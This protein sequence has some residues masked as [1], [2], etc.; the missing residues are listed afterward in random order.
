[1]AFKVIKYFTDLQDNNHAYEVDSTYPREGLN[2]LPS[3]IR[4]LAGS[5]NRRG[6]PLIVEVEEP[7]NKKT[8]EK[9]SDE[10]ESV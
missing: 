1:M 7:K 4:E 6:E 8:T 10:T 3:R 9:V 5:N 2:V